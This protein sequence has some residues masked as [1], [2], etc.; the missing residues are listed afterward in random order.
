MWNGSLLTGRLCTT[1]GDQFTALYISNECTK[2]R[3]ASSWR[4]SCSDPSQFCRHECALFDDRKHFD[5]KNEQT[6]IRQ[7]AN[8]TRPH[9]SRNSNDRTYLQPLPNN[10]AW[11]S[12]LVRWKNVT[13]VMLM[14]YVNDWP[15]SRDEAR[16]PVCRL[17][18]DVRAE[19]VRDKPVT[20]PLVQ[21]PLRRLPRNCGEISGKS[22]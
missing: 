2:W 9:S 7:R 12:K 21:I 13:P 10:E 14:T 3:M 11:A 22:A 1:A 20:S 8:V 5:N 18:R 17:Y 19:Q 15:C 16:I 4:W 6:I